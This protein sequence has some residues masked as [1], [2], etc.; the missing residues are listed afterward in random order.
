MM[1]FLKF[2]ENL[3]TSH[4][5]IW[6]GSNTCVDSIFQLNPGQTP[7]EP[8]FL[9]WTCRRIYATWKMAGSRDVKSR[10]FPRDFCFRHDELHHCLAKS[11]ESLHENFLFTSYESNSRLHI[12]RKYLH[13]ILKVI[14]DLRK[15]KCCT[16]FKNM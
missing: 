2:Y 12:D 13:G 14:L 11:K 1:L 10:L 6:K 7:L 3:S 15:I 8:L 9:C 16:S 4:I 5:P